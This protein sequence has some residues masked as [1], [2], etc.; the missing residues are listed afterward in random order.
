LLSAEPASLYCTDER[1]IKFEEE[2]MG[3]GK[4]EGT[5]GVSSAMVSFVAP[6]SS[7]GIRAGVQMAS[8]R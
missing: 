2:V 6:P 5:H 1:K 4:D 7:R 8:R 3:W